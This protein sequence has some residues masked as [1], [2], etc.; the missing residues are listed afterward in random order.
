MSALTRSASLLDF[1][2]IIEPDQVLFTSDTFQ[3]PVVTLD[4]TAWNDMGRPEQ[5]T[6]V[7]VPGS[8]VGE[9]SL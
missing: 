5:V 2:Q 6:V 3:A 9:A 8:R 7:V 4:L 1:D